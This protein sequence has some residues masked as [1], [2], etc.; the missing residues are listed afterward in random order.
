MVRDAKQLFPN[1]YF[2]FHQDSA[3]SHV[4]KKTLHFMDSKMA[5]IK[6]EEWLLNSPDVAPMDYFTWGY[7]KNLLENKKPR[8]VSGLKH[9]L[10]KRGRICLKN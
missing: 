1:D 4:S 10:K 3:P 8:G 6:P 2:I 5:Y 9:A 7:L